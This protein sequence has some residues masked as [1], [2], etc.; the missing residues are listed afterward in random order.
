VAPSWLLCFPKQPGHQQ[1]ANQQQESGSATEGG[2]RMMP[3]Q[4]G[5]DGVNKES[6]QW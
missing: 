4:M 6:T 3:F 5:L 2:P 1:L